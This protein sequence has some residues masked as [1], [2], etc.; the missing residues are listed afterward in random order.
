MR[1]LSVVCLFAAATPSFANTPVTHAQ[2]M[3]EL[4][5]LEHAGYQPRTV[6]YN[7]PADIQAAE[8]QV[9]Q[10]ASLDNTVR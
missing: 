6:A 7:Y 3:K 1:T 5:A 8:A 9:K 4:A 2:E 10:Q